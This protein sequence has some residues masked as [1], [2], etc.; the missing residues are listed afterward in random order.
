MT[1]PTLLEVAL[2]RAATVSR[3]MQGEVLGATDACVVL[4]EAAAPLSRE[5]AELATAQ[6]IASGLIAVP[7]VVD[8]VVLLTQS[9]DLQFTT[10]DEHRCLVAPV[11]LVPERVAHEA[12]RGR[13]PGLAGLPWASTGAVAD[14]S[15][16]TAVERSVLVDV[17]SRGRPRTPLERF[18]F[19][20]TISRYLTRPALP[21]AINE[22]LSPFVKRIA[23]K[24]DK[25][26]PEGRCA[27]TLSELRL[28]A[29]PDMDHEEPALNVLMILEEAELPSL[30]GASTIDDDRIDEIAAAGPGLAAEAVEFA[31]D[32]VAK[33]EAWMALA[34][35]WIKPSVELA[36][37]VPGVG[38]VEISV[39]NGE[40]LSYAR[41]LN[42]PILD[43]R[44]LST[45]VA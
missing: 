37:T 21:D 39:L 4:A 13:R 44:Y 34:E 5:A 24:H 22:V 43:L 18:H 32:P 27:H 17:V 41:S 8:D 12:W 26:S 20:E 35:C 42:A 36:P 15:R 38:T 16:I 29:T 10:A 31:A 6:G 11:M 7:N 3:F 1:Q 28:E 40:E 25:Q 23:E 30:P 2:Q 45:R 14:L 33:R 9:C 19:A